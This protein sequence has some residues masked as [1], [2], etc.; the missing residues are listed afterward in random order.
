MN[1]LKKIKSLTT[2]MAALMLIVGGFFLCCQGGAKE[3]SDHQVKGTFTVDGKAFP[4][5]YVY[6]WY[7]TSLFDDTQKDLMLLFSD[8][9]APDDADIPFDLGDLGKRGKIH[10]IEVRYSKSEESIVGGTIYHET[11]GNMMVTFS[12]KNRVAAE[13]TLLNEESAEGKIYT[14]GPQ[15][16]F[17]G[18]KWEV[19]AEFKTMLK[20]EEM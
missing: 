8:K 3:E 14:N 11:F 5:K 12:G 13:F 20:K 7:D 15:E 4:L 18:N 19:E 6:T 2:T 1:E 10:A 9:A 17:D 16:S